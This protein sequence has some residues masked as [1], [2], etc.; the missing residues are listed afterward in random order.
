MTKRRK[1][2][3]WEEPES[4]DSA[5]SWKGCLQVSADDSRV[6]GDIEEVG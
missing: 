3:W 1:P 5:Q 2:Q 6:N 4:Y